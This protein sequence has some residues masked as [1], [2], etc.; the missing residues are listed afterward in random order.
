MSLNNTKTKNKSL[1]HERVFLPPLLS[2][3]ARHQTFR[4]RLRPELLNQRT[5]GWGYRDPFFSKIEL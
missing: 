4:V 3:L 2:F 5:L 1:S